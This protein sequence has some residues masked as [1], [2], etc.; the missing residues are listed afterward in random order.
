MS[1]ILAD[2]RPRRA[3]PADRRRL[4]ATVIA[5]LLVA[6]WAGW[7]LIRL[8]GL[9]RGFPL[10]PM[11]AF[12]PY[13]A[14]TALVPVAVAAALRRWSAAAAALAAALLLAVLVLPRAFGDGEAA[15]P[16]D[17][18]LDVMTANVYFGEADPQRV[19][20]LVR[21]HGIDVLSV[22]ELTPSLATDLRRVGLRRELPH[23]TERAAPTAK[24]SGVYSRYPLVPR[25]PAIRR[26]GAFLM[27]GA[28]IRLPAGGTIEVIAVHPPP[29]TRPS[30]VR[31]WRSDLDGLPGSGGRRMRLLLGDFN[32]TL[33]HDR[34]RELIDRG[35]R[36][37]AD[38]VGAGLVPTWS[39]PR[40]PLLPIGVPITIDH[41][42]VDERIGV[43]DVGVHDLP[44]SD[45]D[46]VTGELFVPAP[47]ERTP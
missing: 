24:G 29:P 1:R 21:E 12:T 40:V 25:G 32:A 38:V 28:R 9:D 3:S 4:A 46:A 19:V 41:L 37:A 33:D 34:L 26:P 31:D 23:S 30:S 27:P 36:D 17:L 18:R 10:V 11:L 20:D 14:A 7:A 43:G 44:G 2:S 39:S 6:V 22:Q 35:Y 8:L 13:V 45:H 16:G 5:W 15:G 47:E 42:L